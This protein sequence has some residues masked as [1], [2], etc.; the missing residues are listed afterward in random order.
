MWVFPT[1]NLVPVKPATF[2]PQ[3]CVL[4]SLCQLSLDLNSW[5]NISV[6]FSFC[7]VF[8]CYIEWICPPSRDTSL[9]TF[10][11][12]HL[13]SISVLLS[14]LSVGAQ[15][16]MKKVVGDNATLPCH[17][18]FPSSS[19]LDIEWLLQKPNSKQKVVRFCFFLLTLT[20]FYNFHYHISVG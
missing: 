9:H 14:V 16:E 11:S 18:Q 1:Q 2:L 12:F 19:S 13:S 3:A 17:H 5:S 7:C 6:Y 10:S 4:Y 20:L 15:T 8:A